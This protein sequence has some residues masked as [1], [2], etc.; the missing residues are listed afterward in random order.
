MSK[1]LWVSP[2]AL[3]DTSSGAARHAKSILEEIVR[4][5][6]GK[7]EVK[8]LGGLIFDNTNGVK[9]LLE[10][11]EKTKNGNFANFVDNGINYIYAKTRSASYD[12]MSFAEQQLFFAYYT[13][14][15][16]DFKP[17]VIIGYGANCLCTTIF[18]DAQQ[19]GIK[20]VYLL[21]NGNHKNY[22]FFLSN[23]VLCDSHAMAKYYQDNFGINILPIGCFIDRQSVV[24]LKRT[25]QYIT[26]I[27]PAPQKGLSFLVKL[28]LIY[29]E[30]YPDRKFL[31]VKS[32]GAFADFIGKLKVKK[33]DGSFETPYT[34]DDF[35]NIEVV[36]HT[37]NIKEIYAIT[38]VLLVPSLGYEAWSRVSTEAIMNGIPVLSSKIG[39]IPEAINGGGISFDIPQEYNDDFNLIPSDED[40]KPW[41]E[42]LDD[43]YVNAQKWESKCKQASKVHEMSLSTKR[44]MEYLEPFFNH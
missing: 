15:A 26:L 40:I 7:I 13:Q 8:A 30:K 16:N 2:C 19:R 36:D 28:A 44:V 21:C 11:Q 37:P 12:D 3:H 6:K 39:G 25:P 17:D 1:I 18:A 14:L 32:R 9:Y 35:S 27:N 22:S 38:K 34:V 42:A 5:S 43:L 20:T 10:Q 24:S 4:A 29:K 23:M 33:A 41:L 31:I